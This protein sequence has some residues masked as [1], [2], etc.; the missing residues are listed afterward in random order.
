MPVLED[1]C[2]DSGVFSGEAQQHTSQPS[3][4]QHCLTPPVKA[5]LSTNIGAWT[6]LQ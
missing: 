3:I 4:K 5:A 1:A 6:R 2:D